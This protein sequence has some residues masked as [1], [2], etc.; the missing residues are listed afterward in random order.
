M[1]IS[2]LGYTSDHVWRTINH[3]SGFSGFTWNLLEKCH[4]ANHRRGHTNNPFGC[5][6]NLEEYISRKK[7]QIDELEELCIGRD[8]GCLQ[9][10]DF[11]TVESLKEYFINMLQRVNFDYV[12]YETKELMVIHKK[13]LIPTQISYYYK[14]NNKYTLLMVDFGDLRIGSI[15]CNYNEDYDTKILKGSTLTIVGGDMNHPPGYGIDFLVLDKN[16][17]TNFFI[18]NGE[19]QLHDNRCGLI[20]AYDGFIISEGT[21]TISGAHTWVIQDTI[22]VKK[23]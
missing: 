9:E 21:A 8:F 20:K 4:D 5:N 14:T 19:I 6:E 23:I 18:S 3:S 12:Y 7:R 1:H 10:V 2:K 22:C 11:L 16:D 15:H 17:P 13:S